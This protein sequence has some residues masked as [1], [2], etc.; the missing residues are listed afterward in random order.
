MSINR[1]TGVN[2]LKPLPDNEEAPQA[3]SQS[4]RQARSATS[5]S[6]AAKASGV[7]QSLFA[8]ENI[9][10]ILA[11]PHDYGRTRIAQDNCRELLK[12][13]LQECLQKV[14]VAGEGRFQSF[15]RFAQ[16]VIEEINGERKSKEELVFRFEET[17]GFQIGPKLKEA[18]LALPLE[19]LQEILGSAEQAYQLALKKS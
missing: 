5:A 11:A 6:P 1:V 7:D 18:L 13:E 16:G 4:E 15:K 12:K 17:N 2:S 9:F 14:P 10:Q 19:D 3:E 8:E